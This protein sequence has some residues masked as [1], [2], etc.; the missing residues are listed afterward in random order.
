M[1]GV[2]VK[3]GV[4]GVAQFKQSINQAKQNLKTL[5]AQL[6]LTEKQFKASGDAET[7]MQ[8]KTEQLKSKLEEQK[9]VAANAQKALEDMTRRGVDTASKSFQE[10]IRTLATAKGDIIDTETA[11]QSVESASSDAGDGVSEMNAQLKRVGDGVSF[12]NVTEGLGKLTSSMEKGVKTAYKLGKRLAEAVLGAGSWADDLHT[13]AQYYGLSDE[14]LQ[15]M[16]KTANLI[17]TPVEA[18]ISAQKKLKKGLGSKDKGVMGAFTALFGEGYDPNVKGWENAFWDAGQA[19]MKF[20][21]EEEKEVYAQKLFG[22]SWSELIPLFEAGREEYEKT[23]KSWSV[24][25]DDQIDALTKMDDEYQKLQQEWETM[26]ISFLANFSEPIQEGMEKINELMNQLTEYLASDEGKELINNVVTSITSGLEWIFTNGDT[27][28]K[29]IEGLGVA[30]AGLKLAE[31]ASNLTRIVA[32][33][34]Q[35]LG[36]GGGGNGGTPTTPTTGGGSG[37]GWVA[38]LWNKAKQAAANS[39]PALAA[40][41]MLFPVVGDMWLNQTNSGRAVRDGGNVIE[42]LKQDFNEVIDGFNKNLETA[43]EDWANNEIVK[44]FTRRDENQDA[45]DRLPTGAD[46]RPAWQQGYGNNYY[47]PNMDAFMNAAD[48]ME[49]AAGELSGSSAG[50]QKGNSE[51]SSAVSGLKG[52]PADIASAVTSSMGGVSVYLDGSKVGAL[53]APYVSATMG[54]ALWPS[55]MMTR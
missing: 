52:L 46:W 1:A 32:G 10:M 37:G 45:A 50:Q 29:I 53:V 31:F 38:G 42:G 8:Q 2:S 51:M 23:N 44:F 12:Q 14:E 40:T 11:L 19:I 33:F 21:D 18:I 22:R 39:T 7:Y 6:S 24:V 41:G 3:M 36:L 28:I 43:G 35:L 49:E 16:E 55:L 27:V 25:S 54:A 34:K 17:D 13:R 47:N 48:K 30:F 5:D 15:R 9:N 4:T 20:A 26:K